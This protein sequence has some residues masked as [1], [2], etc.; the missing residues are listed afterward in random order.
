M[1]I[2]K[3]ISVFRQ[4]GDKKQQALI[5][6]LKKDGKKSLRQRTSDQ[7]PVISVQ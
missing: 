4:H 2:K 1:D 7:W 6:Q 3:I 5:A